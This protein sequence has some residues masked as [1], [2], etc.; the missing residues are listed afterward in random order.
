M[1]ISFPFS[2]QALNSVD[3][4]GRVSLPAEFRNIVERRA[5]AARDGGAKIDFKQVHIGE[6]ET[7]PCLIG[8]DE[9]E[10]SRLFLEYQR[11]AAAAEV[12]DGSLIRRG[13]NSATFAPMFPVAF[14][15]AGRMVLDKF[16]RHRSGIS[17]HAFFVGN[18]AYFDIWEPTRAHAYYTEHEN[19]R[20]LSLLEYHCEEK[21]VAL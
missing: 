18:G 19:H 16:L 8:F 5:E 1:E 3:A 13:N 17:G 2:G 10:N 21:G 4:K 7:Q 11:R 9:T 20:M 14:D 15:K 6:D 12:G